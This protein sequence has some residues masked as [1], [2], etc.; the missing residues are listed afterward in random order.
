MKYFFD[1]F[2]KHFSILQHFPGQ[3]RS[4]VHKIKEHIFV[5]TRIFGCPLFKPNNFR[6]FGVPLSNARAE[7]KTF[8]THTF[9][10]QNMSRS[11]GKLCGHVRRRDRRGVRGDVRWVRP[12]S[13]Q[14][15]SV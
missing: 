7:K 5:T 12:M 6:P 3:F 14:I 15:Q 10:S 8:S 1:S 11:E 9:A 13:G 2:L 4:Y